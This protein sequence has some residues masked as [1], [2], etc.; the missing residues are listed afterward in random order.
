M[1]RFEEDIWPKTEIAFIPGSPPL[2]EDGVIIVILMDIG[3]GTG[4]LATGM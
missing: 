2:L 1:R 4:M 3:T